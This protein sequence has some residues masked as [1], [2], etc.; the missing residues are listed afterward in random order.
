MTSYQVIA[1]DSREYTT[2]SARSAARVAV[3]WQKRNLG[4]KLWAVVDRAD[5]VRCLPVAIAATMT[6]TAQSLAAAN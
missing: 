2:T 4:P 3:T 5:G 6:A 1:N